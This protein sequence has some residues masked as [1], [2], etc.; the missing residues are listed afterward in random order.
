MSDGISIALL[1][2]RFAFRRTINPTSPLAMHAENDIGVTALL[3]AGRPFIMEKSA[4]LKS[5]VRPQRH[6]FDKVEILS[7]QPASSSR[8]RQKPGRCR[9][10]PPRSRA[11]SLIGNNSRSRS[12]FDIERTCW[13]IASSTTRKPASRGFDERSVEATPRDGVF[14]VRRG[15]EVALGDLARRR[16]R[17]AGWLE[18]TV[19][20]CSE[21]GRIIKKPA[22]RKSAW[23][24]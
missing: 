9:S 18:F 3:A 16:R 20:Q 24:A 4:D 2:Q 17:D 12:Q 21:D 11:A 23:G 5:E 15:G 10:K 22:I 7:M 14:E 8:P 13:T 19:R 6:P 1:R